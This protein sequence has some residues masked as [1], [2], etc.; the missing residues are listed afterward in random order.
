MKRKE[1]DKR[2]MRVRDS[3]GNIVTDASDICPLIADLF[4]ANLEFRYMTN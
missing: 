2:S 1:R 4:L 3:D